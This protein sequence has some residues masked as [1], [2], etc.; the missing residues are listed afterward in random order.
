MF[1][2]TLNIINPETLNKIQNTKIL[3]IGLGGVGG[4]AF[5]C[6]IRLGF[7]NITIV[8]GDK[9]EQSNLNRQ[10]LSLQSNINEYKV[11]VAKNRGLAI[12]PHIK[13]TSIK[14]FITKD[15]IS[16][17]FVNE[18]DY[19]IDACDTIT[20]KVLLIKMAQAKNYKIISSMGTGNRL[21][22]REIT[23]TSLDKT[24]NDPV[25]K[26]MRNMLKKEGLS[27]KVPVVWSKELPIRKQERTPDSLV[28][29]PN[30]AGITLAYY[31]LN[32]I[33]KKIID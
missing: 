11:D 18:Y 16:N 32:D 3:L 9:F 13:I 31:V 17:L 2:R 5:E 27:L 15:N 6:L 21:N 22:P 24:S 4:M 20:T 30:S 26:I 19:I 14:E 29:V 12:N 1:E 23:I 7:T 28:L 25:A 33:L 8:D 10:I